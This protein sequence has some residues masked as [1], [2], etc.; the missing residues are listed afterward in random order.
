M[1]SLKQ[2]FE[3][4]IGHKAFPCVGAKTA[5]AKDQI[6]LF[7]GRSLLSPADDAEL[8]SRLKAYI[9]NCRAEDAGFRSFIA[10]FPATP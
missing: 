4:F 6:E 1:H 2:E 9:Q 10:V 8:L 3:Q 5:L 7:E